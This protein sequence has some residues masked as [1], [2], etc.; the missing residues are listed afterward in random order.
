MYWREEGERAD[1]G[2]S[3]LV[4]CEWRAGVEPLLRGT[5]GWGKA[6]ST[7]ASADPPHGPGEPVQGHERLGF[8]DITQC[9]A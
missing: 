2:P 8:V 4:E 7:C 5:R 1:S 6:G 3:L 9:P